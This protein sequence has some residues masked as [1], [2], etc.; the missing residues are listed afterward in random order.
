[1][2]HA[3]SERKIEAALVVVVPE[4]EP[5]VGRF[6]A[7]YDPAAGWGV[8]AH[9]S[10]NY[11]FNSG[12]QPTADVL[13]RLSKL[14]AGNSPFS[15]TLDHI[16]RFPNVIYLAPIPVAPFVQLIEKVAQEFPDSPPYGGQFASFTPHLTVAYS[17]SSEILSCVQREFSGAASR[18]LPLNA[19]AD[20]VWLMDD[21]AGRWETRDSFPLG[22]N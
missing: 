16:A 20:R 19:F 5:L 12:V 2:S 1:M 14:F 6:R 15:F 17:K 3:G 18:H 8:P 11:P 13:R 9:I 7:E 21:S 4:A 22:S 10:I